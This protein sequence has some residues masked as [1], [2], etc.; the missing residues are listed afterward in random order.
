MKLLIVLGLIFMTATPAQEV[1]TTFEH[2]GELVIEHGWARV[3][4]VDN[5]CDVK[6]NIPD[7]I[8]SG[9]VWLIRGGVLIEKKGYR[10]IVDEQKKSCS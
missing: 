3:W 7:G 4:C 10:V 2:P 6:I 8:R 5:E 1:T 9:E